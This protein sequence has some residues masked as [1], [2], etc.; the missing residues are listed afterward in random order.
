MTEK[1]NIRH[2]DEISARIF[3]AL[4]ESFPLPLDIDCI[5]LTKAA[6]IEANGA[7]TKE[8]RI[9]IA[10]LTWLQEEGYLKYQVKGK[11]DAFNI[12]LTAKGLSVLKAVPSSLETK[13]SIGERLVT[14]VKS[15][16]INTAVEVLKIIFAVA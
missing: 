3:A 13:T 1:T 9:C 2:F 11:F 16:A 10:T 6:E 12:V 15:G 8:T 14:A 7:A 5:E 4:Y